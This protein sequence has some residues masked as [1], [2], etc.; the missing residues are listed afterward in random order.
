MARRRTRRRYQA[1]TPLVSTTPGCERPVD[2]LVAGTMLADVIVLETLCAIRDGA[3]LIIA[4]DD[5]H[6]IQPVYRLV[7][8]TGER[9][10]HSAQIVRQQVGAVTVRFESRLTVSS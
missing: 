2:R 3:G 7:R 9:L 8:A 1:P 6:L 5:T 4:G 10:A